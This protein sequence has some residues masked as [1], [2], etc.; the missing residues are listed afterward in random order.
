[1]AAAGVQEVSMLSDDEDNTNMG[2]DIVR[3]A[4]SSLHVRSV[5]TRTEVRRQWDEVVRSCRGRQLWWPTGRG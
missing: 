2:R 5:L 1:M 4:R 3:A